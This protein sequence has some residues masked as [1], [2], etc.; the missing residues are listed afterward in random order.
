MMSSNS[1]RHLREHKKHPKL[2]AARHLIIRSCLSDRVSR[3]SQN[4]PHPIHP[5]LFGH[6]T[7]LTFTMNRSPARITPYIIANG[8][9]FYLKR[10]PEQNTIINKNAKSSEAGSKHPKNCE[11]CLPSQSCRVTKE[12]YYFK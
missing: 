2:A 7:I 8:A 1:R 6:P 10:E 12:S 3:L 11:I 9:I 5:R 4:S